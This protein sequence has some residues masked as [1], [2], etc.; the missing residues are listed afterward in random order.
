MLNWSVFAASDTELP[1]PY[2]IARG[3]DFF[4]C[5]ENP[6]SAFAH[7]HLQS[8]KESGAIEYH[9]LAIALALVVIIKGVGAFSLDPH[10]QISSRQLRRSRPSN[11]VSF[12]GQANCRLSAHESYDE[13]GQILSLAR[14]SRVRCG[15]F[16]TRKPGVCWR[17]N[18]RLAV[19]RGSYT[20]EQYLVVKRFSQEL[21]CSCPQSLQPHFLVTL[22]RNEDDRNPVV[23]FV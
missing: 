16:P 19:Q 12:I 8:P 1:A 3:M 23:T 18:G 7:T 10:L 4:F 17:H 2:L 13:S 5:P 20:I 11:R 14:Q 15:E 21:H 9:L 22:C 6:F